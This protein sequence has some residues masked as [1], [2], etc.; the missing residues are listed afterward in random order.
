MMIKAVA[1]MVRRGER[2]RKKK[3]MKPFPLPPSLQDVSVLAS[4]TCLVNGL[5]PDKQQRR[6]EGRRRNK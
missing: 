3:K 6:K 1:P 5:G 2:R 4:T